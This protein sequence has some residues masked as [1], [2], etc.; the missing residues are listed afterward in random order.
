MDTEAKI[1]Q[2]LLQNVP[3]K[4]DEPVAAPPP[5]PSVD[6]QSSVAEQAI[7]ELRVMRLSQALGIDYPTDEANKMARYVYE[8]LAQVTAGT[9]EESVM[10]TLQ[11]YLTRLGLTFAPD[12]LFKLHMWLKLNQERMMI[13]R[14]MSK[15]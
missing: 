6:E 1:A 8:Q 15:I 9:D 7:S 12:R 11:D 13:E 4:I 5:T 2:N 14:E 10:Q 3:Q